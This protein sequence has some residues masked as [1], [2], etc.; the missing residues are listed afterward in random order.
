VCVHILYLAKTQAYLGA[1]LLLFEEPPPFLFRF[2]R[3]TWQNVDL[4]RACASSN[5]LTRPRRPWAT[6]MSVLIST[7]ASAGCSSLTISS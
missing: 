7:S 5:R 6:S 4:R 2:H 1:L 3:F